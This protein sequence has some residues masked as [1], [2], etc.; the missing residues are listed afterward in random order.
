M[1]NK[2][3]GMGFTPPPLAAGSDSLTLNCLL[4]GFEHVGIDRRGSFQASPVTL[5]SDHGGM[6]TGAEAT[7]VGT[8]PG[9]VL[10][11]LAD[12]TLNQGESLRLDK[13]LQLRGLK[14]RADCHVVSSR[15]GMRAGDRRRGTYVLELQRERV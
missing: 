1:R 4:D 7:L 11:I 9:N 6:S 5:W 3:S 15:P 8:R 14:S 2:S 10:V 12:F 13:R